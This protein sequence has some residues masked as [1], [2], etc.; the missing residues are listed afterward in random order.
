MYSGMCPDGSEGASYAMLTTLSNMGGTVA[1]DVSTLLAGIWNV[2]DSA[3]EKGRYTGM[4]KYGWPPCTCTRPSRAARTA[5]NA[6]TGE[7]LN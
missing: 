7:A 3:I 2:S 4:W 6:S 5:M 1:A